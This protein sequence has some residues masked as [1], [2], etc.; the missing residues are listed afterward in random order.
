T[1]KTWRLVMPARK[2]RSLPAASPRTPTSTSSALASISF[3]ISAGSTLELDVMFDSSGSI[4][5]SCQVPAS[6][7][8][9]MPDIAPLTEFQLMRIVPSACGVVGAPAPADV[10]AGCGPGA[11]KRG[12]LQATTAGARSRPEHQPRN[13]RRSS[14]ALAGGGTRAG[15]RGA[16]RSGGY[17]MAQAPLHGAYIS[18]V[19]CKSS[20]RSKRLGE[21]RPE[22]AGRPGGPNRV[23]GDEHRALAE[24]W[25][26]P[27]RG[28]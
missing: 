15:R 13:V 26:T 12:W 7:A 1:E 6:S 22:S 17:L 11:A 10:G 2:T 14:D 18:L 28:G 23:E 3:A 20:T 9:Q 21:S 4:P 19:L 8:I 5:Q 24:A 25:V 27:I 16:R